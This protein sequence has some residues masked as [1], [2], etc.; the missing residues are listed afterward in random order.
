[1]GHELIYTSRA[2]QEMS[3]NDLTEL[4]IQSRDKNLRLNI[5]GLLVYGNREFM[6]LLEGTKQDIFSLY[7]AIFRDSRHQQVQLLWDGDIDERSFTDWS[8]AFINI[9][10]IDP[11]SLGAYST[12]LQDGVAAL[13]LTGNQSTG[14]RLLINLRDEFLKK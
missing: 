5:T 7:E 9:N 3:E 2:R 6:Q 1:M 10:N 8:M 12:F 4:L 14:R 13:H 11:D